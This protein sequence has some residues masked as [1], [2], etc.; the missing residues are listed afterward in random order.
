[1]LREGLVIGLLGLAGYWAASG[2]SS[3]YSRVVDRSPAD[4]AVA[5]ADLDIRDQPGAPGTD[6]TASGNVL[7]TFT[8]ES[9]ADSVTWFVMSGDKVAVRM[10]AH[11]EPVDGGKRTKVTAEV[12]R[13]NAPDDYVSPAFRSTGVTMGLFSAAL[14]DELDE[15]VFPVKEWGPNCDE[16][17][18]RFEQRNAANT[19]QH[20]PQSMGQAF[21][22]TSKAVMSIAAMDKEL[23]AA[24][25][26]QNSN[27]SN[28]EPA[29]GSF[30]PSE[31][32]PEKSAPPPVIRP[33]DATKPTTDLSRYR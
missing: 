18:A 11:L 26:P 1:M 6:P 3:S 4:V 16:I 29:V 17:I 13:G 22:G 15:L 20:N 24:G 21:A 25:C 5:L 14:E 19:D 27:A 12:E 28:Y 31:S 30:G 9:T 2:F 8:V 32:L 7:P 10:I 23:K 33:Q